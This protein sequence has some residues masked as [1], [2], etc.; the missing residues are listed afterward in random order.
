MGK[1]YSFQMT[2]EE[3]RELCLRAL[4]EQQRLHRFRVFVLSAAILT[5][6]FIFLPR[7]VAL[8]MAIAMLL[9]LVLL[10]VLAVVR[11][12]AGLKKQLCG[13]T[14]TME[15]S[16]GVLKVG[17]EGE[18]LSESPCSGITEVRMTRRLLLLGCLQA[19]RVIAWYPVPLRVFADGQERDRFLESV[20]NPQVQ[21]E[22]KAAVSG[23]E[24]YHFSYQLDEEKYIRAMA[25]AA[26][27][28]RAGTLGE[29][30][31]P[32]GVIVFTVGL[33]ALL[34]GAAEFFP[35]AAVMLHMVS[36]MMGMLCLILLRNL[37]ENPERALREQFRK[38]MIKNDILGTWELS[39]TEEGIRRSSP[40][41]GSIIVS[42]ESLFCVVE[43]DHELLFFQ[44][45]KKRFNVLLKESI[46]SQEQLEG[47]KELCREK[48]MEVFAAKRRRYVP[49]WFIPLLLAFMLVGFVWLIYRDLREDAAPDQVP[50]KEQVSGMQKLSAE[51]ED[52]TG[53]KLEAGLSKPAKK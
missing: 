51:F 48:H 5:L 41:E 11:S 29:R 30:R 49:N 20:R 23:V 26:E 8:N 6:E 31:S 44:K 35:G 14:R 3:V 24:Y 50:F 13:K 43:T 36:L 37:L 1:E 39:V 19:P 28:L 40:W 38:G 25:A 47:L 9:M 2:E 46:E 33:A 15:V 16:D 4:W 32:M 27:A 52:A 42:W 7:Q 18:L 17:V 53:L 34:C 21:A 22:G 10:S 12:N 45:D